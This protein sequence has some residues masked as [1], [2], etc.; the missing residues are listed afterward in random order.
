MAMRT[1]LLVLREG[2]WDRMAPPRL[3]TKR[4]LCRKLLVYLRRMKS[5]SECRMKKRQR[6]IVPSA[7]SGMKMR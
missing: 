3:I 1:M 6:V 7:K 2:A 4:M 5:K